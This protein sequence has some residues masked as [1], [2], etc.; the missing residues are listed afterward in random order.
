MNAEIQLQ[1]A[2]A[3]NAQL[4]DQIDSLNRT[5]WSLE[6]RLRISDEGKEDLRRFYENQMEALRAEMVDLRMGHQEMMDAAV[7]RITK[8]FE[9]QIARL[10]EERDAALRSAKSWRGR[11]FGRKSERNAGRGRD[12]DGPSGRGEN[13][14][15]E[16][17]DYVDA[18]SQKAKD[19]EKTSGDGSTMDTEKL[20]KR[21]KRRHPGAEVTVE[22]VDY[23]KAS[24]YMS[25]ENVV[26]HRLEE[27][28][29]LSDGEYFRTGKNGEVEKSWYR[30][31]VRYPERYE[32]HLYEAAHVRSKTEDEYKTTDVL[33]DRRPVPNCMF[34][35]DMLANILCEKYLYHTPLEQVVQKLNHS[36][37]NISPSVLGEHI[38]NAMAWL[39]SKLEECWRAEVRKSWILMLDETR[40]L[41]GCADKETRERHYMNRYMWGIRANSANLVWFLYE[42]GSRGAE[43]IRPFLEGFLGFYTTDGYVVYKIFD[44][45]EAA[46]GSEADSARRKG[47]RSACL[48]HIRRGF[49]EAIIE[50]E[51]EAMWFIDE[52][53]RMFSVEH[54][55]A[56][57]G[58]TGAERL[59]ER[60][61]PGSTADIMRRIEERLEVFRKSNF[62]GCG[63]L[64]RKALKYA[65]GEWPAMKRVL[66]CG[67]V[68][69]SNNLSEQ[70]MRRIK[71][72]LKNAG[73]IGSERSARH[74]AFM[75]S[76]I[77]SCK[78]MRRN[79]ED[80]LKSLLE[81]LRT[82]RDGD[83]LTCCLP[84]YLPA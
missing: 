60:L 1:A 8:T 40:V 81:R 43:A 46:E 6:E 36:G 64:L 31:M 44:S 25:D 20:V 52:F 53:G 75:Y 21:L 14:E 73:N 48:V 26:Y 35:T 84:C 18:Q 12:D 10:M 41:V 79:V 55:C 80:Y 27:Y 77:E 78:M 82:A 39:S 57:R 38:H 28:F 19:A 2:Y 59:A 47:R 3:M 74:N 23:S 54:H 29:T 71:M 33:E 37:V 51:T 61:K 9:E 42:N 65:I 13:R 83:D 45:K 17:D 76:V 11:N 16:K 50:N 70:M 69:L 22:R 49:V 63:E 72:N 34:G 30:I 58:L 32:E 66:E 24:Q 7:S 68:E 56:E 4:R 67:D 15:S 5:V 62:A